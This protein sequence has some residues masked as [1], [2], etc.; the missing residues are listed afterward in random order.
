MSQYIKSDN[1]DELTNL[2]YITLKN[3]TQADSCQLVL[4][5]LID[6]LLCAMSTF[7]YS[8]Q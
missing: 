1:Y 6:I 7:G 3:L 4:T 5:A 8:H 2:T